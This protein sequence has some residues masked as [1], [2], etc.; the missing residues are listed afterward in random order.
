M[1][2]RS[3][4]S[5]ASKKK[6]LAT[7]TVHSEI[8]TPSVKTVSSRTQSGRVPSIRSKFGKKEKAGG[9]SKKGGCSQATFS[10]PSLSPVD[11]ECSP[12]KDSSP[13]VARPRSWHRVPVGE[14]WWTCHLCNFEVFAV[15]GTGN[16][17]DAR[18]NH[19]IQKH[20]LKASDICLSKNHR[21]GKN[22]FPQIWNK[23]IE[24]KSTY[25]WPGIHDIQ[26]ARQGWSCA[27]CNAPKVLSSEVPVQ[28][29]PKFQGSP[30]TVPP[31][32]KRKKLWDRWYKE[33]HS[34]VREKHKQTLIETAKKNRQTAKRER[35]AGWDLQ[36]VTHHKAPVRRFDG[37]QV[38]PCDRSQDVWW[39]CSICDFSITYGTYRRSDVKS[40]HLKKTH[41][42][43][44]ISLHQHKN[45]A[46]AVPGRLINSQ[47]AFD[48]RWLRLHD[49]IKT[50]PWNGAHT[51]ERQPAYH[52]SYRSK[53]GHTWYRA[54]YKCLKCGMMVSLSEFPTSTCRPVHGECPSV[55][56]RK[57]LWKEIRAKVTQRK[58]PPPKTK[59]GPA[60]QKLSNLGDGE[61][62]TKKGLRGIRVGEAQHPGPS[63]PHHQGKHL[64]V[65]SWNINSFHKHF[66]ELCRQAKRSKVDLIFIQESGLNSSQLPAASHICRRHGWQLE[67]VPARHVPGG[68]RGGIAILSKDNLA[69]TQVEVRTGTWGQILTCE[70]IGHELPITL[71]CAYRRPGSEIDVANQELRLSF[72]KTQ[73]RHWVFAGDWNSN[74]LLNN[75]PLPNLMQEF[76]GL[77]VAQSGHV[78]S[79]E[80]T[81]SIWVSSSLTSDFCQQLPVLS[82]HFGS[83]VSLSRVPNRTPSPQAWEFQAR[84]ALLEETDW[85]LHSP[86]EL[87]D[88]WHHLRS[89]DS[90]W[91]SNL[92]DV[93]TAWGDWS[94]TAESWLAAAGRLASNNGKAGRGLPPTLRP[95]SGKH[96]PGQS[97]S[98][99]Q[100]RRLLRRLDE[101][102]LIIHSGKQISR[103]LARAAKVGCRN[104]GLE[105]QAEAERWGYCR[106]YINDKLKD[107]LKT[108]HQDAIRHWK[109]KISTY[110]GACRYIKK[111]QCPPWS[112]R[113][114]TQ[115]TA[116]RAAGT[117]LLK[118]QWAQV[119][120]TQP[121]SP[122]TFLNTYDSW[123]PTFPEIPLPSLTR[124]ELKKILR[125]MKHKAAGC[126][127]WSAEALLSLPDHALDRLISLL[128]VVELQGVWPDACYDWKIVFLPKDQPSQTQPTE[129]L[130]TRPIA[131]GAIIFRA[132]GKLRFKQLASQ[133]FH[134]LPP[135]QAGGLPS[136]GA[137]SLLLSWQNE[138]VSELRPY[139][140]SLDF[141]KAF[142]STD[143]ATAEPLL[144]RAG[145]PEGV[146]RALTAN[147]RNQ[148]RWISF[149]K[150]VSQY[151]LLQCPALLQGD[152]WSPYCMALV[153]APV[154]RKLQSVCPQTFSITYMD[155]RSALCPSISELNLWLQEWRDFES[156]CRLK[157]N[158][159]KSQ[160]WGK[161]ENDCEA[162]REAGFHP[163]DSLQVLGVSLGSLKQTPE[164][165]ARHTEARK[166]AVKISRLP[167][168]ASLKARL[169][170]TVYATKAC[171]GLF[172]N[173]RKALAKTCDSHFQHYNRAC[174]SDKFPGGR[175][176]ND[177]RSVF[178]LSHSCDL[179]LVGALRAIRC[180]WKWH[181]YRARCG[182]SVSW[183]AKMQSDLS[184]VLRDLGWSASAQG[185]VGPSEN[186]SCQLGLHSE[187][188]DAILHRIRVTWRA[189]KC[190]KWLRSK[191]RDAAIARS[192]PVLQVPEKHIEDIRRLVKKHNA[193]VLAIVSGGMY[194]P[195]VNFENL[196]QKLPPVSSCPYCYLNTIPD[197]EHILW[198]C[199]RFAHLRIHGVPLCPLMRRIGW[200]GSQVL[201]ESLLCQMANIRAE[202]VK[203]R[204]HG[205]SPR[206]G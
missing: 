184:S 98:E 68:G 80:P 20:G 154:L 183:A 137:D 157:T 132:R 134:T 58:K 195:A 96:S 169:A 104:W 45:D 12:E 65:A 156:L 123:I 191:R 194:S 155:D 74:P 171:W 177:L 149:G 28:I 33:A 200:N 88:L 102:Q 85:P 106:H 126:D 66:A 206:F 22:L 160:F 76:D 143:W 120:G 204:L 124:E 64:R 35:Q 89:S 114:G 159:G 39:R 140:V 5:K 165:E 153:L 60:K 41:D 139:G 130:K 14:L 197:V 21:T 133:L 23:L 2:S 118:E 48:D 105:R 110:E 90:Q 190:Q 47:K 42:L 32:Q 127:G 173:G 84:A 29:C 55:Q 31:L 46:N 36:H 151:P 77:L 164:D 180:S 136:L 86:K 52:R 112:L 92:R 25:E 81:D 79:K 144:R 146:V 119:F 11:A 38:V 100:L 185:L 116:S 6:E 97:L 179:N 145:I 172:L 113:Y 161:S 128:E 202:E 108:S 1:K 73:H 109:A 69:L 199:E 189:K 82:D 107:V 3:T 141:A 7:P 125:G 75:G 152:P 192:I 129:V 27:Q 15:P 174:K 176:S 205:D 26:K 201:S 122:E 163:K 142:D 147:W 170:A 87:Q 24:L 181:A 91:S 10:A 131:V 175:A 150:C 94:A 99:R 62:A 168:A 178:F 43:P 198:S 59:R 51:L 196:K 111:T 49:V 117:A 135:L 17:F 53:T 121:T 182:V 101:I 40:R 71:T 63:A 61:S 72:T 167:I 95:G 19:L 4:S 18:R 56:R 83:L 16:H 158:V 50:A 187:Y 37:L 13:E 203:L 193:H 115:V 9:A 57:K 8:A 186:L 162:L 44:N 93:N 138:G 103:D 188:L 70:L 34:T 166:R 67:A 54:M 30:G 78:S 148:R